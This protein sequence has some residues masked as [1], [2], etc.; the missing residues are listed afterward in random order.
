MK[1]HLHTHVTVTS[2]PEHT[3]KGWK[4]TKIALMKNGRSQVDLMLT[5]HFMLEDSFIETICTQIMFLPIKQDNIIRVKIEQESNFPKEIIPG[6]YLEIHAET[7]SDHI[8][9]HWVPSYNPARNDIN[10]VN[11]RFYQGN[12]PQLLKKIEYELDD[13]AEYRPEL[14][15]YDSNHEHDSW[16]A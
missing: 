4:L 8:P 12:I 6:T 15:I 7:K 10:F 13:A 16:W 14:V 3:P 5:K 9:D 2:F 11:R 1:T